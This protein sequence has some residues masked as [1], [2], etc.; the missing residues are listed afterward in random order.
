VDRFSKFFHQVIRKKIL[1][2]IITKVSTSHAML[3][4]YLVIVENPKKCYA[5]F[6]L[7]VTNICLTKI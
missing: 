5:I 2:D 7:N 1:Y 4:H 3:L 6:M